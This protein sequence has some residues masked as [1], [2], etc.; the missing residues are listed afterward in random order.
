M[1]RKT[2]T[3][4]HFIPYAGKIALMLFGFGIITALIL[5]L[6]MRAVWRD[7]AAVGIGLA[8][9]LALHVAVMAIDGIAWRALLSERRAETSL[10]F[11]WARWVRESTNLLLPV[12]Q[13]GGEVAGARL[14]VLNGMG[15]RSAG[16]SVI[17]DKLAEAISQLAFTFIGL[18]ILVAMRGADDLA[19]GIAFGLVVAGGAIF[20]ATLGQRAG[21]FAFIER[22]LVATARKIRLPALETVAGIADT[23]RSTCRARRLAASAATHLTAWCLGSG[24]VW[25]ALRFMGHPIGVAEAMVLESLG[26]AITAAGFVVPGAIGIQESGYMAVGAALGLPAEIGLGLSLVKR[27]RQVLLGLP[28]LASWQLAECG[29]LASRGRRVRIGKPV[30]VPSSASNAYVRRLVRIAVQPFAVTALSPNH[31]TTLRIVTGLAACVACCVGSVAGDWWAGGL[32]IV[33]C[34]LDR[35]DGEFAR[36]TG[37]CS[38]WGHRYDYCSDVALNASVFLAIGIGLRHDVLGAW[39]IALGLWAMLAIA[40]ASIAADLLETRIGEK[41]FPTRSGFDFDDILF[42][43]AP[44]LWSGHALALLVGA[45]VGGPVFG[46]VLLRRMTRLGVAPARL[47]EPVR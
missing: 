33:S 23:L 15:L 28:A 22:A 12:A 18:C 6:D 43:L 21:F 46:F 4:R 38:E 41:S 9:I 20:G 2:V 27:A 17:L 24:E 45:A 8:A 25:L 11:V 35:A 32:W 14:L 34:L 13:V 19:R 31:I 29:W 16:A 36:L 26:S 10:L 7:I 44:A 37:R 3:D 39:S 42:V 30:R 5:T 40:T 1:H 47:L